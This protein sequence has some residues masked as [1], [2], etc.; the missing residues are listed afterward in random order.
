MHSLRESMLRAVGDTWSL[1]SKSVRAHWRHREQRTWDLGV[2]GPMERLTPESSGAQCRLQ[3]IHRAVYR[4][5]APCGGLWKPS[6]VFTKVR[7][8]CHH[9]GIELKWRQAGTF[10]MSTGHTSHEREKSK[11]RQEIGKWKYLERNA[12]TQ[13]QQESLL[14]D[15]EEAQLVKACFGRSPGPLHRSG[16]PRKGRFCHSHFLLDLLLT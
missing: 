14:G 13:K 3:H 4:W 15:D 11:H 12:N 2:Q 6:D 1:H 16:R 9:F 10:T 5:D 8:T 7:P